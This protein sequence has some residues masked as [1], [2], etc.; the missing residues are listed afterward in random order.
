MSSVT[1]IAETSEVSLKRLIHMVPIGGIMRVTACGIRMRRITW[2][3]VMP[4][5]R[6]ASVWPRPTEVIPAR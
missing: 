3:L 5:A 4:S 1:P 6:L 2:A